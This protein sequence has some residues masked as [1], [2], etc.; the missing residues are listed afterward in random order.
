MNTRAVLAV[1]LVL[2]VGGGIYALSQPAPVVR[3]PAPANGSDWGSKQNPDPV[4]AS[5]DA[6]AKASECKACHAAEYDEW[7]QSMHGRAWTDPMV[8]AL[9]NGFRMSECID[10]HA[11]MPIHETGISKRVAVRFK[12]WPDDGQPAVAAETNGWN[13]A[14]AQWADAGSLVGSSVNAAAAHRSVVGRASAASSRAA[15]LFVSSA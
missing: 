15:G 3:P 6:F 4:P 14:K 1:V 10:C 13:P 12:D 5:R 9:S 11:P 8:Q 2:A 7:Q